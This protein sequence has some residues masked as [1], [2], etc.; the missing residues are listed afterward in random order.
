MPRASLANT[1]CQVLFLLKQVVLG[2]TSHGYWAQ[3][4]NMYDTVNTL[5]SKMSAPLRRAK[6]GNVILSAD[7]F[8]K[9]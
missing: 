7:M 4:Q 8:Y 6:V 5:I 3:G 1:L 9:T 2:K